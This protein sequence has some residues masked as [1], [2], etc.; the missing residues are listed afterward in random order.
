[1][2]FYEVNPENMRNPFLLFISLFLVAGLGHSQ[3]ANALIDKQMSKIPVS[4]SGSTEAIADYINSNFK[5]EGD[6]IR[7]VFYWTASN[8]SYDVANMSS[9]NFNETSQ[10]KIAKTLKTRKGVCIHYAEVFNE[11]ANKV[12]VKCMIVDGYTKQNGKI[13][14]LSHAWCAAIIDGKWFLFDPTWGSGGINNG[15][16]VKKINDYYFK[17]DPAKMISSHMP[18]DYLW[19]FLNYPVSNQEFYDGKTQVNKSKSNFDYRAEIDKQQKLSD[20]EKALE[21]VG[22]MEKNG[23]K[24][25]L[26]L[27]RFNGKKKELASYRQN[28]NVDKL[29]SIIS[30]YNQAVTSLNDFIYYRNK[31][32]KPTL[33]DEEIKRMIQTPKEKLAQCQDALD[34]VGPVGKENLS[35]LSSLRKSIADVLAQAEEHESFV[36]DYLSKGKGARKSMFTKVSWFGIPLN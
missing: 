6:K 27:E 22:R 11:I 31:K 18:F 2:F 35:N 33:P 17:V 8:I 3:N 10:E 16:F 25:S 26:L 29:N 28:G 20:M 4:S 1:M 13:S 24:N 32:F 14:T 30:D 15:V 7:A 19:Q 34:A 5:T 9:I 23:I 12:G 21:S 36:R